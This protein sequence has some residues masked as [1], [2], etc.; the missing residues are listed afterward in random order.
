MVEP[1]VRVQ[2][3]TMRPSLVEFG[4]QVGRFVSGAGGRE[5]LRGLGR[6]AATGETYHP[7]PLANAP[8]SLQKTGET[9]LFD[10]W[11]MRV[12]RSVEPFL[13][14]PWTEMDKVSLQIQNS[15]MLG[16][17][18]LRVVF[19]PGQPQTFGDN[20]PECAKFFDPDRECYARSS[21]RGRCRSPRSTR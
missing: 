6:S 5:L 17:E 4:K 7:S 9:Y 21:P 12:Q 16:L 3:L 13:A 18:M 1:P 19:W 2:R 14:V 20:H 10:A 8:L 15:T 11:G